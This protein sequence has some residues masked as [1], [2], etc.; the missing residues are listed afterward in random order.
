[1]GCLKSTV[2]GSEMLDV[3]ILMH[4]AQ[5]W[6]KPPAQS[7]LVT[8]VQLSVLYLC[9]VV[10][11]SRTL[12]SPASAV[13]FFL[14]ENLIIRERE[15]WARDKLGLC[16]KLWQL[17]RGIRPNTDCMQQSRL[18]PTHLGI[19]Q[20]P[21]SSILLLRHTQAHSGN[22]S[23]SANVQMLC[24]CSRVLQSQKAAATW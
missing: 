3:L 15:T 4:W 2:M 14:D 13:H 20:S 8:G 12:I 9:Q 1:M 19:W 11:T 5:H 6:N 10:G 18:R 7:C 24:T 17:L 16:Y 21:L 23:I 22:A